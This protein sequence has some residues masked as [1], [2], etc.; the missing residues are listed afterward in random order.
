MPESLALKLEGGNVDAVPVGANHI[1]VDFAEVLVGAQDNCGWAFTRLY[2]SLA[3]AVDGYLRVQGASE[4]EDLTSAVF[5][6]A[7]SRIGSF[8]G[9]EKGFRSWVFTIAHARLV[10]DRRARARRPLM[11]ALEEPATGRAASAESE[12]LSGL[13]L[14]QLHRLLERLTPDQRAVLTLRV[15]ADLPIE[16]VASV[17]GKAPGA[18]KALQHRA[19]GALRRELVAEGVSS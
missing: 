7:F 11:E 9:D 5:L 13:G 19:L 2:E 15:L 18:V 8:K 6:A 1:G 12:A 4:P 16:N 3:A 14:E 10:D 17:L